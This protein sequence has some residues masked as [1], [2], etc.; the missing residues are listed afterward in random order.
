M[1]YT[2]T[3][4]EPHIKKVEESFTTITVGEPFPV[5]IPHREGAVMELWGIGLE[6]GTI[7]A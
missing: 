6:V 1:N 5:P 7:T 3:L 2:I 4:E